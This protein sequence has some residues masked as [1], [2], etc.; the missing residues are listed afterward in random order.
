ME[1]M[2]GLIGIVSNLGGVVSSVLGH[3]KRKKA[4]RAAEAA[5]RAANAEAAEA[6]NKQALRQASRRRTSS[7]LGPSSFSGGSPL[8][9]DSSVL[10]GDSNP[11][12]S[13]RGVISSVLAYRRGKGN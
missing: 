9:S 11:S 4:R 13:V 5:A 8:A 1:S 6:L 3:N 2:N 10:T 12:S 7:L